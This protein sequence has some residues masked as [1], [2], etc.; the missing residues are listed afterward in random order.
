MKHFK[1]QFDF[2]PFIHFIF[3]LKRVEEKVDLT[4]RIAQKRTM[5]ITKQCVL[6][7]TCKSI[8]YDTIE[9]NCCQK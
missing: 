1:Q 3:E 9:M 7:K 2:I 5:I 8:I 6:Q 4:S